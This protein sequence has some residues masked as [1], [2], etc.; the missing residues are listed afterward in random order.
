MLFPI[1]LS[2]TIWG[3]K[4]NWVSYTT[5]NG[6]AKTVTGIQSITTVADWKTYLS[7]NP[8]QLVY[9][10]ATPITYQLNPTAIKSLLGNNNVF[11]D[12]NGDIDLEYFSKIE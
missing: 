1:F 6:I 7:N 5:V 12:T 10:L 3:T 2:N 4:D 11:A 9:E 8:L